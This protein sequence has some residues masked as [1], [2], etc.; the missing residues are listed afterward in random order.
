M[1]QQCESTMNQ[2]LQG[3]RVLELGMWV[4]APAAGTLLA[5]WGAS[6]IKIEPPGGDPL[7]GITQPGMPEGSNPWFQMVNRGKRSMAIDLRRRAGRELFDR[8]LSESDVLIVNLQSSAAQKLG[9]D[10][11]TV[12][13][14]HPSLLYCR[15]TGYGAYGPD[16]DRP[17]FDS[18]AFWARSGF[19]T[20][21]MQPGADPPVPPSGVGDMSTA[22][23]CT[24][25][26]AAALFR[27]ASTGEGALIDVSLYRTGIHVMAW[28]I[29]GQLR[30]IPVFRHPQ[31]DQVLNALYNVYRA[32]DGLDFY[33]TMNTPDPY[34]PGLCRAIGRS[35]LIDDPRYDV[36]ANRMRNASGL[37]G[38]LAT[39]SSRS[40]ISS[41]CGK[42][43]LLLRLIGGQ[44]QPAG[45][46]CR[47]G[48]P[49][50]PR[51]EQRDLY[52]LRRKM[53]MM[54][55]AGG[56]FSDLSVFD[57]VAYPLREHTDLPSP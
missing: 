6:V 31:R 56:L 19:M 2:P 23:A 49:G 48:R 28:N 57:N 9:V 29:A 15:I 41:G 39:T 32:A 25:A 21:M 4:A 53:G 17:S 3:V 40:A 10:A 52:H 45:R 5:D 35:E 51:T 44:L 14:A 55:Q 24:G 36:F 7:R 30:G 34:W 27:R 54:F 46:S 33:L 47:S 22:L 50:R 1:M 38:L 18:G 13:A 8:L 20:S 43:T 26:I 37:V 11:E 16:A 12:R 42:T